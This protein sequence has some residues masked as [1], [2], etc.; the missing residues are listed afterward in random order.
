MN[1]IHEKDWASDN[2]GGHS[3]MANDSEY[4]TVDPRILEKVRNKTDL[5]QKSGD[6]ESAGT[7]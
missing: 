1:Q 7:V 4:S 5:N 2:W 3:G 6:Q